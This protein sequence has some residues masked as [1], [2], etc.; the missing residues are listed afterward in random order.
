MLD[1]F[2]KKTKLKFVL[3]NIN[4]FTVAHIAK[5]IAV[6]GN[7]MAKP[8][9]KWKGMPNDT[10]I[11]EGK[12]LQFATDIGFYISHIE[13]SDSVVTECKGARILNAS[14]IMEA[15]IFKQICIR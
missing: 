11:N 10:K 3:Y 6:G 7:P 13:A 4:L 1:Q 15:K 8:I 12:A 2:V 5:K 9:K 14:S